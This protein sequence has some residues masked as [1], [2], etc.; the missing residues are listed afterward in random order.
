MIMKNFYRNKQI[1]ITGGAGFIGSHLAERLVNLDAQVTILDNL[2]SG[3]LANLTNIKS[4]INF[5]NGDICNAKTCLL[6]TKNQALI[7]HLAAF[8]SAAASVE[9]P[10]E[11]YDINVNGTLNILN[12]A[13]KNKVPKLLFASSAAVYGN[14]TNICHEELSC[15]PESPYGAS[16]LT[17]EQ[18]CQAY[19][20]DYGLQT[21][22]L[23]YFNVWGDRQ[24]PN[25][26]YAAA[27]AKF[28]TNMSQNLPITIYGDGQQTRDFVHVSKIVEAN[29]NLA[30]LDKAHLNGQP[31]NIATGQSK[32]L[33]EM[34]DF[35]KTS[36][37]NYQ[38]PIKFMPARRGDIKYSSA[39]N[40]KL[41]SLQAKLIDI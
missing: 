34:L 11:C 6:A 16:K 15:I 30:M 25:G 24:D 1:L 9:K 40:Q 21:L 3:N 33:L 27:I 17:G 18:Y 32:S 12:A 14:T 4:Q 36:Y 28:K 8:V 26:S 23:R 2:S 13:Y 20:K 19:S 7:F 5:I 37:P 29:L 39:N 41:N 31:V 38:E 35:L 22:S 10:Y